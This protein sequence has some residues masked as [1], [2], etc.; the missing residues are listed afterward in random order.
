MNVLVCP[1]LLNLEKITYEFYFPRLGYDAVIPT[2]SGQAWITDL[3]TDVVD[4]QDPFPEGFTPGD[5]KGE[6]TL[7]EKPQKLQIDTDGVILVLKIVE[8]CI[9]SLF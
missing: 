8:F 2:L 6:I 3:N 9:P 1:I 5:I 7:L 4:S